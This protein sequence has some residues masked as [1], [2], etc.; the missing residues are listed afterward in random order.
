MIYKT[1]TEI[2]TLIDSLVDCTLP[3]PLWTHAAHLAA[4][5]C[6]LHRYELEK[7]V[8]DMPKVIRAYNEAT[9]TPNTDTEGYHHT[10]TLFYLRELDAYI[11]SLPK[12]YDFVKACHNIIS[13]EIGAVDYPFKFYSKEK[14]FSLEAR[15]GW[16][17]ADLQ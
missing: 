9:G 11:Q 8:N 12:G 13:G 7:V 14:L 15:H 3:R 4:G 1:R 16:A 2:E 6:M 5:F 17:D 10:L